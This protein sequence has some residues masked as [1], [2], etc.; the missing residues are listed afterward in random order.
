MIEAIIR[1]SA[2]DG[3]KARL[4]EMGILGCTALECKGFGKQK[5]HTERYRGAR[6]DVGFVPKVV[7]KIAVRTEDL[8]KAIDAIVSTARTG[9]VGDG[10]LFVYDLARVVRIRTGETNN[11]AL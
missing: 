9:K 1:P 10:K 2:L 6:M 3:I 4:A 5:G 11:D 7:L 8:D